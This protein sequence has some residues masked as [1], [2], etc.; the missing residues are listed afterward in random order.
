MTL[1][2]RLTAVAVAATFLLITIGALV[3][4]TESGLGCGTDWPDCS[5]RLLPGLDS[6]AQVIE[7]SHRV[8]ASVVAA[9][10]GVVALVAVVRLRGHRRLVRGAIAAFVL[11]LF[12]AALGMVVVKLE[13]H[14]VSVVLHLATALSL[15]GLLV[16]LLVEAHDMAEPGDDARAVARSA[17]IAAAAVLGLLLLGSYLSGV[18]AEHNAGFPDWPLVGRTLVPDLGDDVLALH[19]L[20]RVV[21]AVVG[22]VVAIAC[23]GI[24]RRR[25]RH[26]RA[27]RLALAAAALFAVEIALGAGN[28][29]TQGQPILGPGTVTLHLATG[30]AIWG[31]LVGVVAVTR[32]PVAEPSVERAGAAR[33]AMES[34]R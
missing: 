4:A 21:A 28:V 27:A 7:F 19:W 22:I 12:Q 29:W 26:P 5:G 16:L 30:A 15:L 6:R 34:A 1:F 24:I 3:R 23:A 13:L 33:P 14:A 8:A 10:L 17:S 32:A 25:D 20:H 11:V 31:L 9:V 2:R 18:G